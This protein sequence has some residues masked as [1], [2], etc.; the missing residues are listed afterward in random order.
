VLTGKMEKLFSQDR[1]LYSRYL[2]AEVRH[3]LLLVRQKELAPYNIS[4]QQ[5]DVVFVIYN[6]GHKATLAEL[7]KYT[8]RGISTLS[9]QL[10]RMEKDGLIKKSRENPK[11][12]LLKYELTKEGLNIY[13]V[14]I[15]RKAYGMIMSVLSEEELRQLIFMLQKI[16]SSSE[17]YLS[18]KF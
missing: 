2:I 14:T 5:S 10:T 15:P 3:S 6:L 7:S 11:S 16:Y 8:G 1:R 13:K 12:A 18:E 4:P 9:I 17:K